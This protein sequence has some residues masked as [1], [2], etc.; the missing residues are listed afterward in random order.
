MNVDLIAGMKWVACLCIWHY[1]CLIEQTITAVYQALMNGTWYVL[2][3][4]HP[5]AKIY[6][7][8]R[9][10]SHFLYPGC[11]GC[12]GAAGLFNNKCLYLFVDFPWYE[13]AGNKL[14]SSVNIFVS[15]QS[16]HNCTNL[17][18]WIPPRSLKVLDA[19]FVFV[20]SWPISPWI[21]TGFYPSVLNQRNFT[22]WKKNSKFLCEFIRLC[23]CNRILHNF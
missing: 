15:L 17:L 19:K 22:W 5:Y 9:S 11:F 8:V 23:L 6:L 14:I 3:L 21:K 12:F 2:V 20:E 18:D 1:K 16:A 7:T 13:G 4:E 10:E